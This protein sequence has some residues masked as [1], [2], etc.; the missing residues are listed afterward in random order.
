MNMLHSLRIP[1]ALNRMMRSHCNDC[2]QEELKSPAPPS[3]AYF[4][5]IQ[6]NRPTRIPSIFIFSGRDN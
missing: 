1:K 4:L 3:L 5:P 6:I 2:S